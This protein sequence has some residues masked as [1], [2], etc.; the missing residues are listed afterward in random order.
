MR[1][2][3]KIG[4][5]SPRFI[6][7]FE[8]LERIEKVA[9]RLALPPQLTGMHNVFHV[10]MLRRYVYDKSHIINFGDIVLKENATYK[11]R[12]ARILDRRV[13]QLQTK[14]IALVKLQWNHHDENEASWELKSEIQEKP[15]CVQ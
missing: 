13:K 2:G 10:S 7:P 11:E 15:A 9:Y 5:L 6:G 14:E 12:P 8:I 3:K 1:F 4:K